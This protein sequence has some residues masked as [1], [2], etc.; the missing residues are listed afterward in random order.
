MA[1]VMSASLPTRGASK[2]GV[3]SCQLLA[4]HGCDPDTFDLDLSAIE[5]A[6]TPR[7]RAIL[8]AHV[9]GAEIPLDDIAAC[10]K[11]HNLLLIED[12][13][14]LI[15]AL[16][17][18]LKAEGYAVGQVRSGKVTRVAEFGAFVELEPGIEGLAHASTF[19]PTGRA[20][21]WTKSVAP[22]TTG[23][24]EILSIDVPQKR[25]GIAMVE[26]GSSRAAGAISTQ[27]GIVPGAIV[28]GKV[29]KHEKLSLIHI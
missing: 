15:L 4:L 8:V 27:S 23:A 1:P 13:P 6:I 18:R 17:D 16:G 2:S 7:T 29:D 28:T 5:A 19:A 22:G 14:G 3:S 25:I 10:A 12:E 24:F 9:F 21:G 20:G 26:E 11:R